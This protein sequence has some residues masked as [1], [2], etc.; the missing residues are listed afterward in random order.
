MLQAG[1]ARLILRDAYASW[2]RGDL[3]TTL[4]YF[5][6]C[7][8]F[9]VH[10]TPSA[11]SLVGSGFGRDRFG[12][13]LELFLEQYKVEHFTL[14]GVRADSDGFCSSAA[15]RYRHRGSGLDVEGRMR[16]KWR[17]VG[18]EIAS[19]ELFT[20]SQRLRAFYNLASAA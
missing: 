20:D 16:H 7:L 3:L 12:Q 15:Y 1:H 18:D 11:P 19:F 6:G 10:A 2:E 13:E 17:F 14:L 9:V 8:V 5:A 4:S